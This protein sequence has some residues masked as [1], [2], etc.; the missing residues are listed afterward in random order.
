MQ[1]V[2]NLTICLYSSDPG[3]AQ[4]NA[5]LIKKWTVWHSDGV[6][7]RN[8]PNKWILNKIIEYTLGKELKLLS[9]HQFSHNQ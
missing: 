9:L 5:G 8:F 1:Y 6:Y 3:Q 7:E 2:I 4:R